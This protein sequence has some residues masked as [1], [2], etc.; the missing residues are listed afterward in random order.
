L[1]EKN[2]EEAKNRK[3][4]SFAARA[5]LE[6]L[7]SGDDEGTDTIDMVEPSKV[8]DVSAKVAVYDGNS[9]CLGQIPLREFIT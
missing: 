2:G 1:K 9:I 3:K 6:C 5:E 7:T 4:R 8:T